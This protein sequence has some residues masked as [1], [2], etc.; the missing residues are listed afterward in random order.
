MRQD[1]A[2]LLQ[3]LP[4]GSA[5]KRRRPGVVPALVHAVQSQE[6][7]EFRKYLRRKG[8]QSQVAKQSDSTLPPINLQI[9]PHDR[10]AQ[11]P[12]NDLRV[13]GRSEAD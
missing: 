10:K 13:P 4:E 12:H 11:Q 1:I 6:H 8:K 7:R 2:E 5:D 9:P 3:S